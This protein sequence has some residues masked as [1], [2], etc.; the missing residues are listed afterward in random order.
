[1]IGQIRAWSYESKLPSTVKRLHAFIMAYLYSPED[2]LPESSM[3][4]FGYLDDAYLVARVYLRT[5]LEV[6]SFGSKR[7]TVDEALSRDVQDWLVMVKRLLPAETAAMD[8]M[9]EEAEL[10]RGG[11]FSGLLSRAAKDGGTAGY[12]ISG[13]GRGGQRR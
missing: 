11:N 5:L 2:F 3:G 10:R 8:K 9:L 7:F 6:D 12:R 1:M 4:F 13:A